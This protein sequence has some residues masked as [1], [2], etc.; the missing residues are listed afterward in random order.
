M[1]QNRERYRLPWYYNLCSLD[2]YLNKIKLKL[3][4]TG[5]NHSDARLNSLKDMAIIIVSTHRKVSRIFSVL[6]CRG[7]HL[8]NKYNL[9]H[10][11]T[12]TS[13]LM[14]TKLILELLIRCTGLTCSGREQKGA[15]YS[16]VSNTD[17]DFPRFTVSFFTP[18]HI[19]VIR[20][21][22]RNLLLP[23]ICGLQLHCT[24]S[25]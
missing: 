15:S 12:S 19:F 9:A 17:M 22:R 10:S 5:F 24:F 25:S 13:T 20:E 11:L 18:P 23:V 8:H 1:K 16:V 21:G 14:M 2:E 4:H 7:N 3:I 6:H